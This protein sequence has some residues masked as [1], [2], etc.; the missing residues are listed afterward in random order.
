MQFLVYV[1]LLFA[2]ILAAVKAK[3]VQVLEML[4]FS[5]FVYGLFDTSSQVVTVSNRRQYSSRCDSACWVQLI[6]RL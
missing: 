6:T 4:G 2:M 5:D 1:V 3:D